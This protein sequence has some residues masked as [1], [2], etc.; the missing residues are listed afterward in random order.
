MRTTLI[1]LLLLIAADARAHEGWGIVVH[2]RHGV[3]VADIPANTIWRIA[4]GAARPILRDTHSHALVAGADGAI[5]GTNAEP[6]G[7]STSVWRLDS[8][9]HVSLVVPRETNSPLGYQS[10]FVSSDGTIYS[11]NRY[12]HKRPS[13]VLMKRER[14]GRVAPIA[15]FT[16]IDGIAEAAD[17]TLIIADGANL[18]AVSRDGR[19]TT[20]VNGLT[21]RRWGEDLLGL[22]SVVNG[23]IHVTD[24]A[25]RRILRV[26]LST[27]ATTVVDRSSFFWAPAGVELANG[28]LYILEHLRPPLSI[29]G[30]LKLG[31]Y[32]RVRRGSQTLA[33]ICGTRTALAAGVLAVLLLAIAFRV[34]LIGR[35]LK[36]PAVLLVLALTAAAV[37][38]AHV[39]MSL[40]MPSFAVGMI[41]GSLMLLVAVAIAGSAMAT[42]RRHRTTIEPGQRPT[43]LVT[44]GVFARTRNPIYLAMLLIVIAI[45]LMTNGLWFLAAAALLMVVLDRLVI[46]WEERTI[47]TLFGEEYLAYR[48]RVR[49]WL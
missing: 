47:E 38:Q 30:D 39:P 8:D 21:Q 9:G 26:T 6:S 11:A 36:L 2:K 44:S 17:G 41:A 27:G 13:V 1:A 19:V 46:R 31:P 29:L 33:V 34:P 5:Y 25:S 7:A 18:R 14:D 12:D 3:V 4:G 10:F 40:G 48:R 23:A 49:R 32:L 35:M 22:S 43:S 42:M 16:A 37:M 28:S 45:G 24:H 20:I 15:P